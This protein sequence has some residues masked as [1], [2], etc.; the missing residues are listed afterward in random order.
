VPGIGSGNDRDAHWAY[1]ATAPD[2]RLN[3]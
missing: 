1:H 3:T 2:H